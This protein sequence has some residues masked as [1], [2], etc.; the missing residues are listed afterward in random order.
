MEF[1]IMNYPGFLKKVDALTSRCDAN[2]LRLFVHEVA[3][4]IQENNRERFCR[5]WKTFAMSW[6]LIQP[7]Y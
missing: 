7:G 4:K 3:R 1:R 5:L 2:S 6:S